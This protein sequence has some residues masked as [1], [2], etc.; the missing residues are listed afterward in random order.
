M[1]S[2]SMGGRFQREDN[3]L[4]M[5]ILHIVTASKMICLRV[6]MVTVGQG[7]GFV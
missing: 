4:V 1:P 5:H 3:P 6:L 2:L 7:P